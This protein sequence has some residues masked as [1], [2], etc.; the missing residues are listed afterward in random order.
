MEAISAWMTTLHMASYVNA[1]EWVW[2]LCEILHFVGMSM[3]IGTIGA[4]DLRVLGL[5]KSIP[6][7]AL[8]RF[9]PLGIAA[10]AINVITGFIFVAG[11]VAGPPLDYLNN[12]SFRIKMIL[13]MLAGVN[14]FVLYVFGVAQR[15]AQVPPGGDAAPSAKVIASISIVAWLG[16]IFFGRMIMYN[17]TL[18]LLLEGGSPAE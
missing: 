8:E 9:V 6:I 13:I 10:F 18:L 11:N 14:I 2:P 16:V 17:D 12:L 3:L 4:W 7:A 5:G 15:E 1:H